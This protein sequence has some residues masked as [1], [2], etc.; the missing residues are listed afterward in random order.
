M[1]AELGWRSSRELIDTGVDEKTAA[2][3]HA[4]IEQV[5]GVGTIHQLRTRSMRGNILV[6][7]HVMVAPR[8][9]VSE[10][11]HIAH[12]VHMALKKQIPTIKDVTIHIDPEDDETKP[13]NLNLENREQIVSIL[14]TRW[15]AIV[16]VD[17]IKQIVLH[18]LE[19]KVHIEVHM[20]MSLGPTK[21]DGTIL[22]Q[23]RQALAG[24][25][26]IGEIKV[27]YDAEL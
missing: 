13:V 20:P 24:L 18:Y 19:G 10:G 4:I 3:M 26:Q 25:N 14:K 16:N 17:A 8:L 21:N 9:S 23:L 6:D 15:Q 7:V 11:H 12:R 5:A 2:N 1:G 27:L 22:S